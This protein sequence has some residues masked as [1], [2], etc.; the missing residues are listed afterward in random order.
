MPPVLSTIPAPHSERENE[1][2]A[3]VNPRRHKRN[4]HQT[5]HDNTAPK[6]E[7]NTE[8]KIVQNKAHISIYVVVTFAPKVS[9]LNT[10]ATWPMP[11]APSAHW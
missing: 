9:F 4:D 7:H 11:T 10:H 3:E 5:Q 1:A 6:T 8:R 2:F